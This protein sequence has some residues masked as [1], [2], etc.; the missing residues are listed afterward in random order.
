MAT[1]EAAAQRRDRKTGLLL[2]V[3][4]AAF[5][6]FALRGSL[7]HLLD[8]SFGDR[9]LDRAKSWHYQLT[10]LDLDQIVKSP[11][12]VIVTEYSANVEPYR[13]WTKDEVERMKKKP[14][15]GTRPVLA[16]F[17]IGEAESYRY[18]WKTEWSAGNAPGWYVVEN[19]AWPRN[20]MVRF[21]HDG[22]RDIVY[23]GADSFLA[24][25]MAAG[26]DGVYLDR[27]DIYQQLLAERPTA[28]EEMINFVIELAETARQKK[29]TFLVVG[30]N[31]EELLDDANYREVIDA[32]GKEDLLYGA[33]GTNM[34]NDEEQIQASLRA[35]RALAWEAKPIFAV[36]YV[37]KPELLGPTRDELSRRG[38]VPLLAH[39][40]LDGKAPSEPR[41]VSTIKYG[42]PEWIQEKCRDKPHW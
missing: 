30:Q 15:G 41:P 4:A 40:S 18:Y 27:I 12:D 23:R 8:H 31:A 2:L 1:S 7:F 9:P 10:G 17:S 39:R 42:T 24:R 28:R 32:L 29:P 6:L 26:F 20:Y 34:R 11:A 16:Y 5:A 38:L 25:I 33:S 3:L 22:W 35:M 37:T 13:A 36:E 21:W 14:D 19:C